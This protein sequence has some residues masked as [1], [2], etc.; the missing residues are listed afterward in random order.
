MARKNIEHNAP[1]FY[2]AKDFTLKYSRARM[3]CLLGG[4]AMMGPISIDIFLPVIPSMAADLGVGIGNVELTL[5]AIFA[6]SAFGQILYGPLS[7]R[8]GRKPIILFCIAMFGVSS[9][10]ICLATSLNVIIFWRFMQGLLAAAGRTIANASARDL[11]ADDKLASLISLIF[12]ISISG[13]ILNPILGGYIVGVFSWNAVFIVMAIYSFVLFLAILFFFKETLEQLD[14][15]AIKFCKLFQNLIF[16]LKKPEYRL[17][18]LSGGFA[19]GA[20]IAFLSSSSGIAKIVFGLDPQSYSYYF[21][22]VIALSLFSNI[23][24]NQFIK[25][26]GINLL[27]LVGGACQT[28]GGLLMLV[29]S[30][31]EFPEPLSFFGPM[32]LFVLG[33]GLFWP[34]T[35]AKALT[36]FDKRV[37]AASSLLGFIQN[38]FGVAVSAILALTIDGTTM[39]IATAITICSLLSIATY[40]ALPLLA[41]FKT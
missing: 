6:G 22:S 31:L 4:L 23:I 5:T 13:S 41:N 15:D 11:Y 17:Y 1:V 12:I 3:A 16:I 10:F 34:L 36:P 30:L 27:I 2:F 26:L 40:L 19:L 18:L 14:L 21:A 38:L 35:T 37:G 29:F 25:L 33:F 32:G 39:P 24:T 8:F 9:V 20:F 7:D 28:I